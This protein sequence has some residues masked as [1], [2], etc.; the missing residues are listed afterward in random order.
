MSGELLKIYVNQLPEYQILVYIHDDILQKHREDI[1]TILT[2]LDIKGRINGKTRETNSKISLPTMDDYLRF[3]LS[4]SFDIQ[5]A[6]ILSPMSELSNDFCDYY[7]ESNLPTKVVYVKGMKIKP[8]IARVEFD[9]V[10]YYPKDLVDK[11]TFDQMAAIDVK[12]QKKSAKKK[13]QQEKNIKIFKGEFLTFWSRMKNFEKKCSKKIR[14]D[15]SVDAFKA[16]RENFYDVDY[17]YFLD[18]VRDID[19]KNI[20]SYY[21]SIEELCDYFLYKKFKN[22]FPNRTIPVRY[23]LVPLYDRINTVLLEIFDDEIS[24]GQ[25]FDFI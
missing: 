25:I 23:Y 11:I 15:D 3:K 7:S 18:I 4:I 14:E 19:M 5:K 1:K 12:E 8:V 13:I 16:Y 2:N 9:K 6:Y 10:K 17:Y 22:Y 21:V 20:K 24:S